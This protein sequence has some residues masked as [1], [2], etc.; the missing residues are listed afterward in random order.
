MEKKNLKVSYFIE[1]VY[2][3]TV[4]NPEKAC[5][6]T[7]THMQPR[8]HKHC[9]LHLHEYC[10]NRP[11]SQTLGISVKMYIQMGRDGEAANGRP[12]KSGNSELLLLF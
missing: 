11:A 3:K 6:R 4:I 2:C 7:Y 12:H 1:S 8:T 5:I 10:G 9:K